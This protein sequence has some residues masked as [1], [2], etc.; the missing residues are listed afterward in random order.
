MSKSSRQAQQRAREALE[1][2]RKAARARRQRFTIAGSAVLVVVVVLGVLIGVKVAGGGNKTPAAATS[3]AASDVVNPLTTVPVDALN[4]VGK[5]QVTTLPS[6]TSGQTMLSDNGKPLIVY[7]G[8]E[9]CPYCAAERWAMVQALSRFGTFSNL[10]QTHSSSTDVFP[11]TPTLSFHGSSYTSQYLSF[12][13]VETETNRQQGNGYAPLDKP[14]AA[15]QA[16][17]NKYDA[18]PYVPSDA[19]GSIPFIDFANKAIVSGSSYS[20]QLLAGKTPAQVAAALSNPSDPIAKAVDGTANAFTAMLC[21]LTNGQPGN[22]C[23]T[24]SATAYQSQLH[25]AS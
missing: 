13:G 6:V 8:A 21:Q 18:A 2:Q 10:G 14:T 23:T 19:A 16:L 25:V 3:L 24:S 9:Y 7:V 22:V 4:Q 5:G 1:A 17:V 11:N 20:P 15:Q 12:Q